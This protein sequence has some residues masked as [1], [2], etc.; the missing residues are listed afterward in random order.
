MPRETR[1]SFSI[2]R[3]DIAQSVLAAR[4]SGLVTEC[5]GGVRPRRLTACTVF[6]AVSFGGVA[7]LSGAPLEQ[8][9]V[10]EAGIGRGRVQ[11][12]LTVRAALHDSTL[13]ENEDKTG[14]HYRG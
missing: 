13:V 7:P 5:V 3:L 12:E 14:T 11:G 9:V 1:A 2:S 4:H 10:H 6:P 8:L